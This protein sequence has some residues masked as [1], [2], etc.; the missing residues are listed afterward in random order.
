MTVNNVSS[1]LSTGD[2]IDCL[3][4]W[5]WFP[6]AIACTQATHSYDSFDRLWK[7]AIWDLLQVFVCTVSSCRL[8]GTA[9]Q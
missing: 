4:L 1:M 2:S 7:V 3:N 9:R 6:K 8:I 5:W